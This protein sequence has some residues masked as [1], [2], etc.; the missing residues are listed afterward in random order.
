MK[1]PAPPRPATPPREPPRRL[2]RASTS[3]S[4]RSIAPRASRAGRGRAAAGEDLSVRERVRSER[5]RGRNA[6]S[7][8]KNRTHLQVRQA[9][10]Q[11]EVAAPPLQLQENGQV[12]DVVQSSGEA[13]REP[14]H[15]TRKNKDRCEM[16]K[17]RNRAVPKG[18][19]QTQ[20]Q[21]RTVANIAVFA[22]RAQLESDNP[23]CLSYCALSRS[24]GHA[25]RIIL[26]M[27]CPTKF[28]HSWAHRPTSFIQDASAP[29]SR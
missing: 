28:S 8:P 22:Q 2:R 9:Q 5:L 16:R 24:G 21:N 13:V 10:R 17:I 20:L 15:G 11:V 29:A 25:Q 26:T 1:T 27:H 19:L 14:D 18:K 7:P 6:K 12:L 23:P 3:Y 4:P